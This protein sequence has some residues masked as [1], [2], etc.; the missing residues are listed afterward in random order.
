MIDRRA[1]LRSVGVGLGTVLA[2]CTTG[3]DDTPTPAAG[4]PTDT[5]SPTP[6][7][8]SATTTPSP[9]ETTEATATVIDAATA[10][11]R[12]FPDYTWDQLQN[13]DAQST[14]R[15]VLE[16]LTF[17]PLISEVPSGTPI[18]FV[19]RDATAHTVTVPALDIDERVPGNSTVTLTFEESGQYDYVCTFHPPDMLGRLIV[20]EGGST[21][22]PTPTPSPTPTETAS[23]T[24]TP[25]P[26]PTPTPTPTPEDDDGG[27]GY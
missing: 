27:D 6:T 13:T 4:T 19:N 17:R 12:A 16:S 8:P 5:D 23:P 9:T 15:V 21:Q 14:T 1:Y 24:P 18:E 7:R 3:T 26:S 11:Q 20:S 2:G 10:G 25:T 22:T